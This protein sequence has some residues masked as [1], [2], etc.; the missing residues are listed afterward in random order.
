MWVDLFTNA[1]STV[2]RMS[3]QFPPNYILKCLTS[4]K[5]G[6]E[7][8]WRLLK[9][10]LLSQAIPSYSKLRYGTIFSGSSVCGQSNHHDSVMFRIGDVASIGIIEGT[11]GHNLP[12]FTSSLPL[13]MVRVI[14]SVVPELRDSSCQR[15]RAGALCI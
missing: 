5:Q 13:V 4:Q 11:L 8:R 15:F 3:F 1:S 2:H 10:F 12:G 9:R 6:N 14:E 7:N